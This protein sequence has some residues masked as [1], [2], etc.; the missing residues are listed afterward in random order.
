MVR[1]S[2]TGL[3]KEGIVGGFICRPTVDWRQINVGG[4]GRLIIRERF[5]SIWERLESRS[6]NIFTSGNYG[7]EILLDELLNYWRIFNIG[8]I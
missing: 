3:G 4:R 6:I 5:S 7:L 1:N 2:S 8:L